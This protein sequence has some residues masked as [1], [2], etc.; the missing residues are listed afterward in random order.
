MTT[1]NVTCKY[2]VATNV[3]LLWT[4][5]QSTLSVYWHLLVISTQR[6]V[7]CYT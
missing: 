5:I 2:I 4:Y 7:L 6:T 3:S 1:R